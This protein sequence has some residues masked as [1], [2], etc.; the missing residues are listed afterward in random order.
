VGRTRR[1][2]TPPQ[3]IADHEDDAAENPA[4]VNPW[5]PIRQKKIWLNPA[6]LRLRQPD[7]IIHRSASSRRH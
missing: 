3:A 1:E 7:Q 4:I 5:N 2:V 6:H